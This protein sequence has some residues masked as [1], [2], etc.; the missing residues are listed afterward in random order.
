MKAKYLKELTENLA[1]DED[2]FFWVTTKEEINDRI[3]NNFEGVEP[4]TDDELQSFVRLMDI[5]DH[6]SNEIYEAERWVLEKILDNRKKKEG[7]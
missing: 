2:V 7:N 4:I 1:Y 3:F 5:D 6:L